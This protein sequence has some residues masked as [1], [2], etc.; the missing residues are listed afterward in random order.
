MFLNEE[1]E[2]AAACQ[3]GDVLEEEYQQRRQLPRQLRPAP[4]PEPEFSFEI[5]PLEPADLP[6]VANSSVTFDEKATT[7]AEW[8]RKAAVGQKLG[9]P[10]LV[11]VSPSGEVL[12][13][14]HATPWG[15]KAAY[16]YTVETSIFLRAATTGRGLGRALLEALVEA[17]REAGI[18]E[19]VAVIAD[20]KADASIALHSR[21]GF[22]EVGRMGRVGFKF[23]RWLGT[24]TMQKSLK[25]RRRRDTAPHA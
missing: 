14:A 9:M 4:A 11:A 16:R 17:C 18:R 12:G 19:M 3:S 22:V 24:V 20:A 21:L 6:Y 8:R 2:E 10:F 15:G 5:R 25:K 7:L 13:Y 23:G 1:E